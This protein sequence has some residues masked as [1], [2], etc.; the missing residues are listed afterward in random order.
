MNRPKISIIIVNYNGKQLLQKC[1]ESLFKTDYENFEVI[2]D[3]IKDNHI[4]T[5]LLR[6][7]EVLS[8][9][10]EV[11]ITREL[12]KPPLLR[13]DKLV[14]SDF[15]APQ[16]TK[17]VWEGLKEGGCRAFKFYWG[18]KDPLLYL[19]DENLLPKLLLKFTT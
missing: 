14:E 16:A 4:N 15:A 19:R 3:T 7:N 12:P 11:S 6:S 5:S 18:G 9:N 10:A 2:L 13:K 17:E 8:A 1:L